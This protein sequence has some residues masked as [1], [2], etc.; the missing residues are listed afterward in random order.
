MDWIPALENR[1]TLKFIMTNLLFC[2]KFVLC[3]GISAVGVM[4]MR[5]YGCWKGVK[6]PLFT[7]ALSNLACWQLFGL[8]VACSVVIIAFRLFWES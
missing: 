5:N 4:G 2:M 1:C 6:P 7:D 3:K 8:S